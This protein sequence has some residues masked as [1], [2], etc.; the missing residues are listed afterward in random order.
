[1]LDSRRCRGFFSSVVGALVVLMPV[2]AIGQ[3]T[4]SL[5]AAGDARREVRAVW[6]SGYET[7]WPTDKVT[8]LLDSV[9]AA[10]F[11]TI[12]I[13]F[14]FSGFVIYPNSAYLAQYPLYVGKPD[15]LALLVREAR[16]RGMRAELLSSD[17]F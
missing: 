2:I 14:N 13:N 5:P 8:A 1:M 10:G 11:N 9:K 7:R 15:V 4:S 3:T 12:S 16:E 6:I 17:G